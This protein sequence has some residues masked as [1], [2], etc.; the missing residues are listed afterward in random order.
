MKY[1]AL[2][3]AGFLFLSGLGN[4]LI[5]SMKLDGCAI[6]ISAIVAAAT[7]GLGLVALWVGLSKKS[8]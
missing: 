1:M 8:H 2:A 7:I 5:I 3:A 6:S 4:I